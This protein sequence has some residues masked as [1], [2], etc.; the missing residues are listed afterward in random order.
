M[1]IGKER[2]MEIMSGLSSDFTPD[3]LDDL[4]PSYWEPYDFF[5]FKNHQNIW[6]KN[7]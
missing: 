1:R 7:K 5:S 6:A 4:V 2:L 3:A